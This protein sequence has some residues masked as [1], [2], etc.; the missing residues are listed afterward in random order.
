MLELGETHTR[1]DVS[2]TTPAMNYP[3]P[4]AGPAMQPWP[5][6]NSYPP[7]ALA[8]A[9]QR[10]VGMIVGGAVL[11]LIALAVGG[12]FF[13]NL[14]TYLT[15]EDRF[16]GDPILSRGGGT[17]WVV[18]L[19]KAASLKRMTI[20]GSLSAVFGLAGLVLGGLGLRKK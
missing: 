4:H 9:P 5:Q 3:Q 18:E 12:L 15:I 13:W 8:R 7:P 19:V 2:L 17:A 6:H 16:A 11:L 14:H 20:F 10:N 1:V